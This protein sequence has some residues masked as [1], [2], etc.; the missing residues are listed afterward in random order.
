MKAG[1]Y[2]KVS[3][4]FYS[5]TSAGNPTP[6]THYLRHV[7]FLGGQAPAVKGLQDIHF[8]EGEDFFFADEDMFALREYSLTAREADSRRREQEAFIRQQVKDGR[9][10]IGLL[11]GALAFCEGLSDSQTFEFSEGDGETLSF[12]QAEWFLD[13]IAKIPRPVVLGELATGEFSEDDAD[14]ERPAGYTVDNRSAELDR[15]AKTHMRVNGGSYADAVR[16]AERK[17]SR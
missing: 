6:G 9:L 1:S 12:S 16:L 3:A 8:S 4:A 2:K 10:P 7:G 14:F 17:L 13:F 5:P 15:I 11:P